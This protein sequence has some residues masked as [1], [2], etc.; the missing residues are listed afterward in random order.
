MCCKEDTNLEQTVAF[1]LHVMSF[2]VVKKIIIKN[3]KKQK[4]IVLILY[5]L[6]VS[7]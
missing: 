5:I 7:A 3:K 4:Q 1:S 2:N 6:K